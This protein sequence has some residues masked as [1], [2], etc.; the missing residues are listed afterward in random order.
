VA[1][2]TADHEP[3]QIGPNDSPDV[4]EDLG[5]DRLEPADDL[6][7]TRHTV[8]GLSYTVTTGRV[9]LRQEVLTDG[10]FDGHQAKAEVFLIAY[11]LRPR[12]SGPR[13]RAWARPGRCR[14]RLPPPCPA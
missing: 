7:T 9:V 4:A 8:A 2:D 12:S 11:T 14:R 6:V 1:A 10:V 5:P 3:D 13:T